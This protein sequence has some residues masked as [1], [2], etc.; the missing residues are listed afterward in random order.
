MGMDRGETELEVERTE[1]IKRLYGTKQK[2]VDIAYAKQ[3]SIAAAT[4]KFSIPRT[5]IGRWMVDGYF[6]RVKRYQAKSEKG[7]WATSYV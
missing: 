5:K 2:R 7:S 4:K 3:H 1:D 6:E